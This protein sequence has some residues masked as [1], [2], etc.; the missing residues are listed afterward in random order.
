MKV[1]YK[2]LK[3]YMPH[4]KW[5]QD[6]ARDLIMHTAEV[7]DIEDTSA[8]YEHIVYGVI[9][10]VVDHENADSLKV[11][12]VDVW[13]LE[14]IQI[15]CWGT[16]LSVWQWVA[17]AKIRASV[18]WH[19][20]GEPVIMKKTTIRGVES[21]GMICAS[22]EIWLAD[23]YP[24]SDEKEILDLTH[25]GAPVW[26]PLAELLGKDDIILEI[27]NKA[28]N[29]RP[30]LFSHIGIAREVAAIS[31]EDFSYKYSMYDF[32]WLPDAKV[33]NYIPEVVK[34]YIACY[35]SWVK[36]IPSPNNILDVI[37]SH[38]VASKGLLVDIS[39]YSLYLYGQPTHC[40]DADKLRWNVHV[41]YARDGEEFL[42]LNDK[43]YTLSSEDIVIA[44]DA[45]VIALWGI[46]GG[47]ASA[48]SEATTR[49]AIESAHFDQAVVR[50]T[51]KRLGL[52]T[53]ALNIFE[54]N[55]SLHLQPYWVSLILEELQKELSGIK[56]E[57]YSDVH[58]FLPETIYIPENIEYIRNLIGAEYSENEIFSILERLGIVRHNGMFQIPHWRS[59]ITT[60]ADIA[61]EVARISGYNTIETTVPRIELGAVSQSSLYKSKRDIRN[62]LTARGYFE[63]YTYSF[64]N[65]ELM[66]KSLGNT[67]TSV[68]LKNVLSEELSH[69]RPSLIPLLLSAIE[70]N[71]RDFDNLRLFECE[72]VFLKQD[73]SVIEYYELS[74]LLHSL[75][76]SNLY[77]DVVS[78][79]QDLFDKIQVSRF[80][81]KQTQVFP[82]FAHT[83]RVAE[84]IVRGQSVWYIWEIH[85][86]VCENFSVKGRCGFI[87]LNLE[88]VLPAAYQI[89]NYSE[90]SQFQANSFDIT[91]VIDKNS[92]W[93]KIQDTLQKTDALI[94]NVE[95]FDIYESEEKLPGKRA[96]SF[97]ITIQS[98]TE[99][100]DDSVK[101]K[102]IQDMVGRVEKLW[103]NLR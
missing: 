38:S 93:K 9:Q 71:A 83:G 84:V 62:F 58:T 43:S 36:N 26:T 63:M 54:K 14:D 47:K 64:V 100:L 85:P 57:V 42:A 25:L 86:R 19:G 68:G 8:D 28:I 41:R 46:I 89:V 87:S 98:L 12:M 51:W 103:W 50:K 6:V 3:Q 2:V 31:W 101:N 70:E 34:R 18:L 7:E 37:G 94:Q 30:D 17:V 48:V 77:Y 45:W 16:N 92:S 15:V 95:L 11:C 20:Q 52:R 32:S 35:V 67:N 21:Y 33:K 53:D 22:E 5:V 60:L 91:I 29:H 44:D 75:K 65:T 97:T 13:E 74:L 40:F 10:S 82:S 24:A 59:D 80:E 88:K 79:L 1:S 102:L 96:L 55:I 78:E 72:K 23:I 99:T 49:I 61:E 81:L 73:N 56:I 90:I 39:N 66:K 27:D 69:M 4:I 76:S